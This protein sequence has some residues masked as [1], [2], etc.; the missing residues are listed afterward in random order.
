MVLHDIQER[1]NKVCNYQDALK[2]EPEKVILVLNYI[3][4]L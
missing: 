2:C 4:E 1:A 3:R